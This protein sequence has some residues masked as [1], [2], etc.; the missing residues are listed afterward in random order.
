MKASNYQ[1]QIVAL[2]RTPADAHATQ[3]ALQAHGVRADDIIISATDENA[4]TT[5]ALRPE[6]SFW[7]RL[8]GTLDDV[9]GQ[10][11]TS[12]QTAVNER[13]HTLLSVTVMAGDYDRVLDIIEDHDPIETDLADDATTTTASAIAGS[14]AAASSATGADRVVMGS[15]VPP[16]G[17]ATGATAG[18]GEERVI[19]LAKEELRVGKRESTRAKTYRIRTM[20]TERPVEQDVRLR[21]ET[22]TVEH[23]PVTGTTPTGDVFRDQTIEVQERKEEPVVDKIAKQTEEVVVRKEPRERVETVRDTVRETHVEVEDQMAGNKPNTE[24]APVGGAAGRPN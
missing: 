11:R 21:D 4:G 19:P 18:A 16:A 14:S 23:R 2:F 24:S 12:Y 3:L 1:Q 6:P 17:S 13:G 8:F 5:P 15:T 9:P 22:V 10:H 7:D 20:V